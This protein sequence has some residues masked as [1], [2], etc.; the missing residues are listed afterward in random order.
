VILDTSAIIAIALKEPDFESLLGKLVE[1]ENAAIGSP[2][3]VETAIVLS[4]RLRQDARG[5]LS[6]FI[7]EGGIV[8]VPFGDAHFSV[9][10]DAWLR[11]GKGRHAAALN[12][13]DCMSYATASLA[14]EPLL[15]VGNDFVHTD[16]SLA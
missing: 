2:T 5:F 4:V 14:G 12:F 3:L 15:C 10:V 1:A 13:G 7:M 9:A 11:Y 16:L 8:T 6:R